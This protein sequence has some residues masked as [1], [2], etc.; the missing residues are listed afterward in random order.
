VDAESNDFVVRRWD[1]ARTLGS[2][3][4]TCE[5]LAAHRPTEQAV[6]TDPAIT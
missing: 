6:I 1:V 5:H 4:G 3:R 2:G